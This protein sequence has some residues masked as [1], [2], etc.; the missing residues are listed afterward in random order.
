VTTGDRVSIG[1]GEAVVVCEN[2]KA[3]LWPPYIAEERITL[4]SLRL[5]TLIKEITEDEEFAGYL[6]LSRHHYRGREVAS[7]TARLV[8]RSFD[9]LYPPVLGYIELATPFYMNKARSLVFDSPFSANGMTWERW[10]KKALSRGIHSV[11]RIARCVI[12]PEFRGVGLGQA[13]VKHA[14]AFA[15]DRWQ[16]SGLKPSFLEIAA[17]MLRFVPFAQKAGMTFIGNT[18]GN[19]ARVVT[20]ISY[21]VRVSKRVRQGRIVREDSCGI[22]DQQVSRMNRALRL[23]RRQR[24]TREELVRQLHRSATRPSLRGDTIFG[25]ILSYPKPTYAVG[26]I[27]EA[28]R[29]LMRRVREL[30]I[31]NGKQPTLPTIEPLNTPII[32]RSVCIGYRSVVRRTRRTHDIERAFGISPESIQHEVIR[33]LSFDIRPGAVVL[34][35]GS[36]GSGKTSL[37]RLLAGSKRQRTRR[38][39]CPSNATLGSFSP[40][41]SEKPFIEALGLRDTD[42]ALYL[43]GA[44]GLSD[45]Y[46]Y[47]KRFE[48]LSNGQQYRAMLAKVIAAKANVW[49]ADEFCANL[50]AVTANV[51]SAGAQKLARRLGAALVV[52]S[53]HP[54]PFV[55]ALQPDVVIQLSSSSEHAVHDG[56]HFVNAVRG[57]VGTTVPRLALHRSSFRRLLERKRVLVALPDNSPIQSGL[58]KARCGNQSMLVRVR[59]PQIVSPHELGTEQ[60]RQAGYATVQALRKALRLTAKT[61]PPILVAE[62]SAVTIPRP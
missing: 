48:E 50:D 32:V 45:A 15:R 20:D 31:S 53:S 24:W 13:L 23:M 22:V 6:A 16:M 49:L 58:A 2:G 12:A 3:Q 28:Q 14:M 61:S 9:P 34:I 35:T 8:V 44:V 19:L 39:T 30:H 21:L 17:D 26:L 25:G 59:Q 27:P 5:T 18:Q 52:A 56:A 36:S 55:H 60:A 37:L 1:Q 43:M 40:I 7:R 62:I 54:Q 29:Y 4:G 51:V 33:D 42:A 11:V 57:P 41:R 46:I 38:V 10:N 47:L